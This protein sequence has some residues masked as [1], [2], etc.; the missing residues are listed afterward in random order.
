MQ[1]MAQPAPHKGNSAQSVV[2]TAFLLFALAG[3]IMGFAVGTFTHHTQP[4]QPQTN[5]NTGPKAAKTSTPAATPSPSTT[6]VA[7]PQPLDFPLASQ[8]PPT[9]ANGIYTYTLTTISKATKQPVT[10]DGI[11]CHLALI[12]GNAQQGP[13][14]NQ[15]PLSAKNAPMAIDIPQPD[16]VAGLIYDPSTPQTQPCKNGVG[17]W[18][19]TVKPDLAPG[20]YYTVGITDWAGIYYNWSYGY[21]IIPKK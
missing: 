4:S 5:T 14:I 17:T 2:V 6:P 8:H 16:E 3:G 7:V 12:K 9:T 21:I 10:A 11:T 20:T 19:F 18:T 15:T 13:H 1:N